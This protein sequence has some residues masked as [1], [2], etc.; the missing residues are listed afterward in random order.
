MAITEPISGERLLRLPEVMQ[1]VGLKRSRL[2]ELAAAGLFPK[3]VKLSERASA[4]PASEVAA[5]IAQRIAERDGRSG[6]AP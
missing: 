3:Q 4:W 2:L 6:S 1:M 5:W